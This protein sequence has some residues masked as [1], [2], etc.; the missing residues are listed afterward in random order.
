M[1]RFSLDTYFKLQG[2]IPKNGIAGSYGRCV[3]TN[4][5][6][7]SKEVVL[8]DV[9]TS[10]TWKFWL[11]HVLVKAWSGQSS[12]CWLSNM[13]I[14]P[15]HW[16]QFPFSSWLIVLGVVPAPVCQPQNLSGEASAQTSCLILKLSCLFDYYV[17]FRVHV[18]LWM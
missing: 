18:I 12:K 14:A 2:A 10:S 9:P 4:H 1:Y 7:V 13:R 17:D 11:L 6:T 16:R 15:A 3:L 5:Q 8:F